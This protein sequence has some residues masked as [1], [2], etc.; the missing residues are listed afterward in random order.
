VLKFLQ[1]LPEAVFL[2][3]ALLLLFDSTSVWS[4]HTKDQTRV[5]AQEVLTLDLNVL[6]CFNFYRSCKRLDS[7][8]SQ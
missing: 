6:L 2:D 8:A 7:L 5:P 3:V 1:E 4:G